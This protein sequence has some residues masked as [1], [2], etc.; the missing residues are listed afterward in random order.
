VNNPKLNDQAVEMTNFHLPYDIVES[1]RVGENSYWELRENLNLR[2]Y[3]INKLIIIIIKLL[4]KLIKKIAFLKVYMG[5]S[6]KIFRLGISILEFGLSL[7]KNI[8][9]NVYKNYVF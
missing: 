7:R 4:K 1:D 5:D 8:F 2:E 9:A 6:W 3:F